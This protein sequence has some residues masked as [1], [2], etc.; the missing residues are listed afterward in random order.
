MKL[1]DERS[2]NVASGDLDTYG[3][4]QGSRPVGILTE[5][6]LEDMLVSASHT[7]VAT[8]TATYDKGSPFPGGGNQAN[9]I[10]ATT[11]FTIAY[12]DVKGSDQSFEGSRA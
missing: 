2:K 4:R 9:A 6:E 8:A 10:Y 5:M 3:Q 11:H 1:S 12:N 7:G